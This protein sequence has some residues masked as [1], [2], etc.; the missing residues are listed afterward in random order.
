VKA[1]TLVSSLDEA[2]A[3]LAAANLDRPVRLQSPAGAAGLYGIGWWLSLTRL[4]ADE[5]PEIPFQATLDCGDS[6]GL[7]LASLR[8]GV[9]VLRVSGLSGEVLDRLKDIARQKGAVLLSD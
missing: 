5:F 7:A 8:A 3:V 4:L 1:A 6:P 2:R 9:P